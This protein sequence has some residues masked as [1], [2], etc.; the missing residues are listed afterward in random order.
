M[1]VNGPL[2]KAQWLPRLKPL[3]YLVDG[4]VTFTILVVVVFA[5]V[6]LKKKFNEQEN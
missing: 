5:A 3:K 2:F 4:V 1:Y 6:K